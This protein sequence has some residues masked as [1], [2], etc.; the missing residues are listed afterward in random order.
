LQLCEP[1]PP[2]PRVSVVMPYY[3]N[4][5][6]VV[7][8]LESFS[9]QSEPPLE[10]IVV[11]DGS[12][13]SMQ[14][15][16]GSHSFTKPVR[17][18]CGAHAG[19]S[20]ATNVGILAAQGEVTLLTCADIIAHPDLIKHHA[21]AH[22]QQREP[23]A[24]MGN[25]PYARTV[26]MTPFMRWLCMPARQFCFGMIQDPEQ[27]PH[28]YCYAPNFSVPTAVLQQMG[29]FDEKFIYGY[30]DTDLGIRLHDQGLRMV[31]RAAAIGYHDH[32]NSV[33]AYARRQF[34]VGEATLTM[35]EK[36]PDPGQKNRF[37]DIIKRYRAFVARL[38]NVLDDVEKLEKYMGQLPQTQ[39]RLPPQLVGL[40]DFITVVALVDGMLKFPQRLV[41]VLGFQEDSRADAALPLAA[42]AAAAAACT[43]SP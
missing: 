26:E 33:R 30:Q 37:C 5:R 34:Q 3:E 38:P 17:L 13:H 21:D 43:V 22:A 8:C 36:Y 10:I 15:A 2:R 12:S 19:Q 31:Y 11:D 24:V 29:G 7:A 1:M 6:T 35:L 23:V 20:A 28:K 32:P 42:A 4:H 40:Y 18:L 25:L 9:T 16:V 27:V 14:E 39:R 41:D